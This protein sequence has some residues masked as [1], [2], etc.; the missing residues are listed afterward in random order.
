MNALIRKSYPENV[1]HNP[2]P[3]SLYR[4]Y[5]RPDPKVAFDKINQSVSRCSL[6]MP[7]GC[8]HTTK[9]EMRKIRM[10][11]ERSKIA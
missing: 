5:T 10:L 2:D 11:R 9:N 7:D 4:E 6:V 3:S 8:I 1:T